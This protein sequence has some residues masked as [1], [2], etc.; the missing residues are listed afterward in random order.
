MGMPCEIN[1]ILKLKPSQGFPE[2]LELSARY[3]ISKEGYRILPVDVPIFL[4]DENWVTH[5]DVIIN[6]LVWEKNQT[7]IN[8]EIRKIYSSPFSVE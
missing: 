5:A 2:E 4:V 7:I 1:T 3:Q 6:R 8:F